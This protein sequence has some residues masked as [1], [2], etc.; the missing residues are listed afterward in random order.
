MTTPTPGAA[1]LARTPNP[2]PRN[3]STAL[4]YAFLAAPTWSEAE[5]AAATTYVVGKRGGTRSAKWHTQLASSVLRAYPRPPLREPRQLAVFIAGAKPF[6]LA[7]D[8]ATRLHATLTI[9]HYVLPP[10]NVAELKSP[11][12]ERSLIPQT[13]AE[14]AGVL[15]L[16]VGELDWFA[17]PLQWNRTARNKRLVHYRHQWRLRPGRTPRLLE[18]P[19]P[20]LREIQRSVLRELLSPLP[21][22]DAAHG[23]TPGRSPATNAAHHTGRNV[24]VNVDLTTFFARVTAGKVFGILRQAGFPE[25]VAHR[26]AGLCTHTVP[27]GVIAEMPQGG[28]ASG[29]FAFRQ[30]LATPHLPQGAPTSPALANLS[31]RRLDSRLA[32]LAASFDADYTRYADDL[33]FSGGPGFSHRS[34][35]FVSLVHKIVE[36]EGHTVNDAKTRVRGSGVQ[37]RVTGVVV[38]AHTNVS[39]A[40]F[41]RLK[42]ILHNCAVHGPAGQNRCGPQGSEHSD[43]R[44]HLQGRIAWVRHLN[45][46]RA[47]KLERIFAAIIW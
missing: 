6:Y 47:A 36:Q 43:F 16:T 18:I 21:L 23:F 29:R 10:T 19:A 32:G 38:N 46:A 2:S 22:H 42:A 45:P 34:L 12:E 30:A 37:Q 8:R 9:A 33:A 3:V 5:L 14:L 1:V 17:D 31:L 28:G 41:D 44:G 25:T 15:D 26:L 20:R 4:A 27:L 24:V 35:A 7:V 40:E 13:L 11:L 39:R